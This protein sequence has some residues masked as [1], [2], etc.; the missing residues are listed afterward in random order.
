MLLFHIIQHIVVKEYTFSNF[1]TNH[2]NQMNEIFWNSSIDGVLKTGNPVEA[3]NF[4]SDDLSDYHIIT[5]A[6]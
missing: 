4:S 2:G 6:S 1:T 5:F 3:G